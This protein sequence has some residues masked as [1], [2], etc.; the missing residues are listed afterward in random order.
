MRTMHLG[1]KYRHAVAR[2]S[3]AAMVEGAAFREPVCLMEP[4]SGKHEVLAGFPTR[5]TSSITYAMRCSLLASDRKQ[6]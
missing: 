6:E 2:A 1:F 3:F 5:Y 4:Q